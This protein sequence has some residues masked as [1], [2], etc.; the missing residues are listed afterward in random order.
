MPLERVE[1]RDDGE[2]F[3]AVRL[4]PQ[5]LR[6]VAEVF[7]R[8]DAEVPSV[9]PGLRSKFRIGEYETTDIEDVLGY[10]DRDTVRS[11]HA[12]SAQLNIS[13]YISRP[14]A[15][16]TIARV[17]DDPG[18]RRS[19]EAA[20]G[21]L[22]DIL[23]SRRVGWLRALRQRGA[24]T[25]YG[26]PARDLIRLRTVRGSWPERHQGTIALVGVVVA[27]VVAIVGFVL[28]R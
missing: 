13:L 11:L 27:V 16:L 1:R 7:G 19:V 23:R 3:R 18:E 4:G 17:P 24:F 2:W 21:R 22:R 14:G 15:I 8:L 28:Q 20:A 6:D 9:V 25:F 5:D 10:Q 26:L 12:A